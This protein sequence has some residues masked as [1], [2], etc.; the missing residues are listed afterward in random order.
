MLDNVAKL[1]SLD[2]ASDELPAYA[3]EALT[4]RFVAAHKEDLRYIAA[5]GK[6]RRWDGSRWINDDTL[7]VFDH[8]RSL[9]RE[10]A[11]ELEKPNT[12]AAVT[13]ARTIAA[14]EGLARSDRAIAAVTEQWDIGPWLLNTPDGVIDLRTG[15]HRI[16]NREDYCTKQCA[17]APGGECPTWAKFLDRVTDGDAELQEFLQRMAGY[18]LTGI[19]T[20]HAIF[21]AFGTGANGKSVFINTLAGI[22]ADYATT[23]PIELFLASQTDRHPTEL[24]GLMGA[25]L[26]SA[27][28]VEE[29]RPWA[30]AKLKALTGG[31]RVTAR[32]MRQNFFEFTPVFKLLVA[33]NHKPAIKNVDEGM[34]RRLRLIPFTVTIPEEERDLELAEKLRA[35]WPGILAWAVE[36]AVKWYGDGLL[37]PDAVTVATT[38]YLS[39]EDAT[40]DWINDRC[41]EYPKAFASNEEVF[42]SWRSWAEKSGEFIGSKKRLGQKLEER[43][44]QR[45]RQGHGGV[46][47]FRG[48]FVKSWA[49][50]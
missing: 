50:D 11:A 47:G 30:E 44:F 32:F 33:G 19:T 9:C 38:A 12:R 8:V 13:N 2:P 17:V 48:L 16:P 34:R 49:E 37:A 41:D 10:V 35:E 28:E 40:G 7:A 23:A 3:E 22:L 15:A 20:E 4:Q 25:R 21:F 5:W 43:G 14:I 26:V 27:I 18:C 39:D 31:D 42:R 36:G 29:G 45:D 1:A 24:A 46:K 6:W